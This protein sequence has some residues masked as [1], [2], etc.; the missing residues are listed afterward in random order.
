MI[1]SSVLALSLSCCLLSVKADFNV[2]RPFSLSQLL[3]PDDSL[4]GQVD[5]QGCGPNPLVSLLSEMPAWLQ[6]TM[7]LT[8]NREMVRTIRSDGTT[9]REF[10]EFKQILRRF[11]DCVKTGDGIRAKKSSQLV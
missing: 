3:A 10:M 2:F 1:P 5:Y 6:R 7:A 8:D 9:L 11:K 4:L